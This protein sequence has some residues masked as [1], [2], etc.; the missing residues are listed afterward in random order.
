MHDA[1]INKPIDGSDTQVHESLARP[2]IHDPL[3]I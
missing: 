1:D 3:E 2:V